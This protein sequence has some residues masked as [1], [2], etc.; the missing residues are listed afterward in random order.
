[1]GGKCKNGNSDNKCNESV[2]KYLSHVT[3]ILVQQ[4]PV[5]T[6]GPQGSG[7]ESPSGTWTYEFAPVLVDDT[8]FIILHFTNANLPAN[9]MVEVDLGHGERDRFMAANRMDFWTRPI[10]INSFL[11]RKSIVI[12]YITSGAATGSVQLDQ[13][14]RGEPQ[15]GFLNPQSSSNSDP[16]P[17]HRDPAN[18][19]QLV[20]MEPNYD[21]FWACP[22]DGKTFEWT[23]VACVTDPND[24]RARVSH[25]VGMIIAIGGQ[26]ELNHP[27]LVVSTCSVTLVDADT[28]LSAEHCITS[29]EEALT[30]SVTFDYQTDCSGHWPVGFHSTFYKVKEIIHHGVDFILLRLATAP[31]GIPTIQMRPDL[32][33]P[34]E[35]IFGIHH[36]NGAV[37]KLS[38]R[39]PD[40]ATARVTPDAIF[41]DVNVPG[42][43]FHVSGGSSGSGLFDLAGRVVGVLHNGFACGPL[44]YFP[45]AKILQAI[46]PTLPPPVTRDVMI[47]FDRSG[48]ML[49]T[50]ATGRTKLDV[51]RD[52]VSLFIQL[53]QVGGNRA[54]FVSFSTSATVDFLIADVSQANKN[55]LIG[56]APFSGGKVGELVAGGTTSIGE[57]LDA[58]I[59]QFP[60][61]VRNPRAILLMT[62]GHENTPR[63]ISDIENSLAG[64]DTHVIGLG[65]AANLREPLLSKLASDHNGAYHR[66][67]GSITL[68]KFFSHA[69]GSIF[70]QGILMDPEFDLPAGRNASQPIDFHIC[71]ENEI[72]VVIGWDRINATLFIVLTTPTG[73]VVTGSSPGV[74]ESF[75][76]TWSFLRLTLPYGGERDGIW[77]AAVTRADGDHGPE[78]TLL[79]YFINIIP[80]GG[81]QLLR[82]VD[83]KAYYTGDSI[84]PLVRL[85]YP[86]GPWPNVQTVQ[87]T[88]RRPNSSIGSILSQVGLDV[89]ATIGGDTIAARQATLIRLEHESGQP[90]TNDVEETSDLSDEAPSTGSFEPAGLFGKPLFDNLTV[91]GGYLFH[92]RATYGFKRGCIGTRELLFSLHVEVGIDPSHTGFSTD[93]IITCPDGQR[94]GSVTFLPRDRYGNELGPGNIDRVSVTSSIGTTVTGSIVDNGDG[95]YTVPITWNPG[96]GKP[97]GVVITQPGR[98]PVLIQ[99]PSN[100]TTPP[101]KHCP[102]YDKHHSGH[103]EHCPDCHKYCTDHD[104]HYSDHDK[105]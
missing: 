26:P 70:K 87:L 21:P 60:V 34:D 2:A 71:G 22:A 79:H 72:T 4:S 67:E 7:T 105:H 89:P 74:E 64:I 31:P 18:P 77:R 62:D 86:D 10:D 57:G 96:S 12:R 24:V 83:S 88:L 58:A 11:P 94:I 95:S 52:A 27:E 56:F 98:P 68:E 103:P 46:T 14:G 17:T 101:G 47:V 15:P 80:K 91:E 45:T 53:L 100:C 50:D 59:K 69:F 43:I 35:K 36:P 92:F 63:F 13:Y 6:I 30:S 93:F 41:V 48:S 39:N 20:Y 29:I 81:A 38:S 16:F 75:G 9:N 51:A 42:K 90:I 37:K 104:K 61:Q 54:G 76:R 25:S 97:P 85:R 3:G 19:N 84:N 55:T 33:T 1:M 65:T 99:P 5:I 32:P 78:P 40:F 73:M 8:K 82:E 66:A 23:N 49:E 102:D 28:V 44:N